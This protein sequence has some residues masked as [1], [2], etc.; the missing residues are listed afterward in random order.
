MPLHAYKVPAPRYEIPVASWVRD[1]DGARLVLYGKGK[2]KR[3]RLEIVRSGERQIVIAGR[4]CDF[5][6]ATM[7]ADEKGFRVA[8]PYDR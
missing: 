6:R 2:F 3:K 1:S 8:T 4:R 7:Y 5:W